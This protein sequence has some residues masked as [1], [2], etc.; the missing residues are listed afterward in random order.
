MKRHE[1]RRLFLKHRGAFAECARECNVA[2][3]SVSQWLR[4]KM[5]SAPL[6]Q[7][8]REYAAQLLSRQADRSQAA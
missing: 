1:L 7:G 4:K 8:I 6:E 3:P 5:N 2:P